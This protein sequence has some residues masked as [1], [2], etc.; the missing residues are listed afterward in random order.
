VTIADFNRDNKLDLAVANFSDGTVSLL[1]GNGN[2]S[3]LPAV[4]YGGGGVPEGL[5]T[6]DFNGDRAPDIAVVDG[7]GGDV[8]VLLNTGQRP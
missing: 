5:V 4:T 3:F 7:S 1:Y 8:T 6:A 2:G